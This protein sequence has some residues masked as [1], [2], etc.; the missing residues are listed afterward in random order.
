MLMAT[1][2]HARSYIILASAT[3]LGCWMGRV[4]KDFGV[5][6]TNS[7]PSCMSQV[8]A[9]LSYNPASCLFMLQYYQRLFLLDLQIKY[10]EDK[11]T[12]CLGDW[13]FCRWKACAAK[14][15]IAIA[16]LEK[17]RQETQHLCAFR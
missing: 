13:L 11:S 12:E 10:L 2:G 1:S 6:F 17:S 15:K 16:G 8:Y 9:I 14:N 5:L 4:V 7:F 3:A